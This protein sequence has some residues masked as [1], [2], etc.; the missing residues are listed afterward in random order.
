MARPGL[1]RKAAHLSYVAPL[2][3]ALVFAQL[4]GPAA[5]GPAARGPAPHGVGGALLL[6]L[7]A[8]G[9]ASA[10]FALHQARAQGEPALVV[11]A[12]L[13]LITNA[14]ALVFLLAAW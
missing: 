2:V 12:R 7:I 8:G 4:G 10:A 5:P 3:A 9:L 14:V 6:A 11:P 1:S 13:G